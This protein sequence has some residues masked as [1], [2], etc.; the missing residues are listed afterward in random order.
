MNL[1]LLA[2]RRFYHPMAYSGYER[3]DRAYIQ[4]LSHQ[5]ARQVSA[6]TSDPFAPCQ[7]KKREVRAM[8]TELLPYYAGAHVSIKSSP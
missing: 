6:Y 7:E 4:R 2:T 1:E 3:K 8:K 5:A